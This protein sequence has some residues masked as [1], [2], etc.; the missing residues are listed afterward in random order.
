M[1][2]TGALN[3]TQPLFYLAD[4]TYSQNNQY[5]F[6]D[7]DGLQ[8]GSFSSAVTISLSISAITVTT[9]LLSAEQTI[10]DT[11]PDDNIHPRAGGIKNA[12][13]NLLKE[14][15]ENEGL[16][17][18]VAKRLFKLISTLNAARGTD[19][20]L[21]E[22]DKDSRAEVRSARQQV[23]DFFREKHSTVLVKEDLANFISLVAKLETLRE[24][25]LR[26][27][28]LL[29]ALKGAENKIEDGEEQQTP[30]IDIKA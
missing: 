14:L 7:S 12:L 23:N 2:A 24:F 1:L 9:G 3:N 13:R 8:T 17:G 15:D 18:K 25:S 10:D 22:L 4:F 27:E 21:G 5:Q 29:A 19:T 20:K 26:T 11:E 30:L 28:D 16:T 6:T